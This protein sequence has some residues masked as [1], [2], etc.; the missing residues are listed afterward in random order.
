MIYNTPPQSFHSR[1]SLASGKLNAT[2]EEL[3]L[4]VENNTYTS[5]LKAKVRS[6]L[7]RKKCRVP[8]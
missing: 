7:I 4:R 3:I 5:Q 2:M 8:L 1:F 6:D